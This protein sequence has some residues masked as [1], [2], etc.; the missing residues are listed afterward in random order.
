MERL[1]TIAYIIL[2]CLLVTS[3]I[4]T[5]DLADRSNSEQYVTIN[6]Q[7]T[8]LNEPNVV[9]IAK[10][11]TFNGYIEKISDADVKIIG[12]NGYIYQLE[13][14]EEGR[15]ETSQHEPPGIV[16]NTY[17]LIVTL[18]NG[19]IYQSA[20]EELLPVSPIGDITF[21]YVK[22]KELNEELNIVDRKRVKIS[23]ANRLRDN[24]EITYYKWN[25][26]GE[27]EF[28]ES[29]ALTDI[30]MFTQVGPVLLTCFV[31]DPIR[32]GEVYVFNTEEVIGHEEFK[33]EI[34]SIDVDY[35]FAF[36]YCVHVQQQ[37]L[38]CEAYEFWRKVQEVTEQEG[39]LFKNTPGNITGNIS[40]INDPEEIVL[41]YFYASSVNEKKLFISPDS[42]GNPV[43]PCYVID[44][45]FLEE[46]MECLEI[47]NSRRG[48]PTYWPR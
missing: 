41:G 2:L 20:L 19:D 30:F 3:C 39:G 27:Y 17:F 1:F 21:E 47:K 9:T 5:I 45:D 14:M 46:C 43:S 4:E 16:G 34:K 36:H 40:N 25:V 48:L 38:T 13:P 24:S 18:S 8:T 32:L 44:D 10:S 31:D 22:E 37:S 11:G 12:S 15:Y 42:V 33:Q 29:E 35:K 26:T 28:R 6:G 7:I 23:V